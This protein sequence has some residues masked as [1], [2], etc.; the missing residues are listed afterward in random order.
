MALALR[1]P[2]PDSAAHVRQLQQQEQ[3]VLANT[4]A[5]GGQNGGVPTPLPLPLDVPLLDQLYT[6]L[7]NLAGLGWVQNG[8]RTGLGWAPCCP[9]PAALA[10]RLVR[11]YQPSRLIERAWLFSRCAGPSGRC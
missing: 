9:S 7:I 11:P 6:S 3:Q 8:D 10:V 4:G 2:G 1:G 5:Q